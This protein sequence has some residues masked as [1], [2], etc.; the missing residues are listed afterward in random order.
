MSRGYSYHVTYPMMYVMLPTP[1]SPP[2]EQTDARENI[3]T[4]SC[5]LQTP[6]KTLLHFHVYYN[7][8]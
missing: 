4:F 6:V 3:T 2:S 7:L 5:L 8:G 1:L